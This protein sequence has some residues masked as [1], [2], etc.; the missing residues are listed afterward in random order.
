MD[1]MVKI[2]ETEIPSEEM[3]KSKYTSKYLEAGCS[4]GFYEKIQIGDVDVYSVSDEFHE[5]NYAAFIDVD[6]KLIGMGGWD[7]KPFVCSRWVMDPNKEVPKWPK[8]MNLVDVTEVDF[9]RIYRDLFSKSGPRD[10][11]PDELYEDF[12]SNSRCYVP[13]KSEAFQFIGYARDILADDDAKYLDYDETE[14][15]MKE[16]GWDEEDLKEF[17]KAAGGDIYNSVKKDSVECISK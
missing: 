7:I 13:P 14:D 17:A 11:D 12:I 8:P 15:L 6:G 16:I 2:N 4:E 10:I 9:D 1:D 5:N 3:N